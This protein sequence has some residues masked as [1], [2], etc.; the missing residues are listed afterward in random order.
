MKLFLQDVLKTTWQN[1]LKTSW[2]FLKTSWRRLE[3]VLETSWR[4]MAKTK[5]LL[6]TKTSGRRLKDYIR[7]DQDTLKT[8][9]RCL[10][11]TK[12][13]DV[14][15]KSLSRWMFAGIILGHEIKNVRN[16][17]ITNIV[18][19]HLMTKFLASIWKHLQ[20]SNANLN[21]LVNILTPVLKKNFIWMQLA[22]L[23]FQC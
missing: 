19:K 7:L 1:G 18:M 21:S 13:K 5:I 15:K 22:V 23:S 4:R 3:N 8:S 10:L 14:S 11:K 9:W 6:L 2:K 20:L 12:T 17:D 16:G